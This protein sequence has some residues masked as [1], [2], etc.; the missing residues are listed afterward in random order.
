MA[1]VTH[2]VPSVEFFLFIIMLLW[3]SIGLQAYIHKRDLTTEDVKGVFQWV[4][5]GLVGLVILA[6]LLQIMAL[7]LK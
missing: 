5:K 3:G 6:V 4:A 1:S 7:V 2:D